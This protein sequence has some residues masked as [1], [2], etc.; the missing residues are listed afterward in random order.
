MLIGQLWE[1]HR[2][3][4]DAV[5]KRKIPAPTENRKHCKVTMAPE[6]SILLL[7]TKHFQNEFFY[8]FNL[9]I[10][11]AL[12]YLKPVLAVSSCDLLAGGQ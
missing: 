4:L 11:R 2:I 8:A 12:T 3:C 7:Y 1:A 10:R 9:E 5:A 6:P